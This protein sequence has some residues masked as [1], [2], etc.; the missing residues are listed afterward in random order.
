MLKVIA[1]TG[2][3]N[4]PSGVFR[5]QQY[6]DRLKETG[7]ELR[8]CRSWAGTH[9]P[10]RKWV[11]PFWGISNLAERFPDTVRSLAYDVTFFQ[12]EML[13]T[14][15]TWE[16]FTRRPRVL[17]IDDAIWVHRGG[18]FIRRLAGLCDHVICG[19]NFL[20]QQFSEW[21]PK[22]SIL[23]TPVNVHTFC[24]RAS[25]PDLD[26]PIIGWM[27]LP[28]N[29]K[30]LGGVER[31]LGEVL[32]RHPKAVLR[33]VSSEPPY[34]PSLPANQIEFV[35]WSSE[36]EARLIQ[37]MTIGIMPLDDTVLSRGK[38]AYKMLLY[39]ACGLPVVVTPVGMNAEVL[40]KDNVG[41]G[42]CTDADWVEH[43]ETLLRDRELS[44]RLGAAGRQVIVQHYSVEALAPKLA[45]TLSHVGGI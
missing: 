23:P 27:G 7:I 24:P 32:R 44:Q 3:H 40:A 25:P 5:V 6:I 2:G 1:Y 30:L 36:N 12:R 29:L 15:L 33:V 17:D 9:P 28:V 18:G 22:V 31:A 20:A 10:R 42:A 4:S 26:R 14:F 19:N 35:R 45:Q 11:R 34:L 38:C 39:M 21:N 13:S 16:P 37:E 8:E 43:L 41:F